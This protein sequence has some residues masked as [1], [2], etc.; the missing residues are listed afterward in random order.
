LA[1]VKFVPTRAAHALQQVTVYIAPRDAAVASYSSSLELARPARD[2]D[3]IAIKV[4]SSDPVRAAAAANFMATH[5][6][7]DR[8]NARKG[9]TGAAVTFLEQQNDSLGRQLRAAEESLREYQQREHVID[10]PEQASAEVTRLAKLQ[11]DLASV[12]AERDAFRQLVQQLH[13]DTTGGTLGGESASR[14][15]MAFPALLANQSASTLLGDLA[16]V[17]SQ[18]SQLLI[19]RTP[20][21]ADVKVLT[22][23]IHEMEGQLQ[24]I[25]ESYLQSLSNQVA[26]LE[27][28]AGKFSTQLDALPEKELQTA[29]RQRDTKVLND[30]WVLVQTRLKEAQM[31]NAGG[32]PTVRIADAASTPTTPIRP[33]PLVNLGLA[34][35][36]GCLLGATAVLARDYTDRSI[37][38]RADALSAVGLPV[39]GAFPRLKIPR[40]VPLLKPIVANPEVVTHHRKSRIDPERNRTASSIAS[41]LVTQPDASPAYVESIN[42]LYVNLALTHHEKPIKVVVFT[43]AL[44]GEGKSLSAINFALVGASRGQ[45]VLL[46]DADLRCGV[47]SS[48]MGI[49]NAPGFAEVLAGKAS[50]EEAT[51]MASPGQYNSLVVLPS[52]MLPKVP[53]RILTLDRVREVLERLSPEFDTVVI[54]SPPI[55]LLADAAL[56][57][58]A[59]D[60]VM[61]VVRVGHT[62]VDDLR[63]AMDQLDSTHAP[64]I[65]TL[66][67]DIDLRRNARDDGSYRY[68]AAAARYNGSTG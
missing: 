33:R 7:A 37:R 32:D 6:I 67:N 26:S 52:G 58:S 21:D 15:L 61:L 19:H 36:L 64:V 68:L 22:N 54:D 16:Q 44:P 31:T 59:A 42:Q 25:A 43:S 1:G 47:V 35:V 3:L 55:N 8:G 11:A 27:G 53:G 29:R 28:E 49:K 4:R 65:G 60:A 17:E 30:L 48:V 34:L 24:G 63:F 20:E 23:R 62:Q 18:R 38:S 50:F 10:V 39:L 66:L 2:A 46:I 12:R 56:L 13:Q 45:R 51:H 5:L 14:R 40:N 57:G 41:L 9:R